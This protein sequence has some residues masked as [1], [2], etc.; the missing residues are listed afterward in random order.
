MLPTRRRYIPACGS[1]LRHSGC[2]EGVPAFSAPWFLRG[3]SGFAV[4]PDAGTVSVPVL[5][6]LRGV[7]GFSAPWC[8]RGV[9]G[10]VALRLLMQC[11]GLAYPGRLGANPGLRAFP[12][13]GC[14]VRPDAGTVSVPVLRLLRRGCG[15]GMPDI[16][17]A[18]WLGY[19]VCCGGV[20]ALHIPGARHFAAFAPFRLRLPYR[21]TAGGAQQDDILRTKRRHAPTKILRDKKTWTDFRITHLSVCMTRGWAG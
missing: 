2:R 6:L 5:R 17:G 15:F 14:A 13:S 8:L 10:F 21:G 18:L 9:S 12:A 11:F 20:L 1:G 16:A 19:P 4:R 7:S 3:F